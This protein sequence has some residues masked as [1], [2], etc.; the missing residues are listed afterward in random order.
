[1]DEG[2]NSFIQMLAEQEWRHNYPSSPTPRK[3]IRYMTSDNQRPIMTNSESILQFGPN[4]Y[5]KPAT[6]LSILRETILGR[7]IFDDAFMEFSTRWMFKSPEPADFF[8]T[9]E[10][11]AGVDLDWFWRS[12]FYT[13]EHVDISVTGFTR[14]TLDLQDPDKKMEAKEKEKG[15][16]DKKNI[17]AERNRDIPKY[18]NE[19]KGLKDFYDK[20]KEPK[21][22]EGDR[23][24]YKKMLADLKP[25]EKKLLKTN[26]HLT[27]VNF[28]NK[29]GAIMP[30]LVQLHFRNGKKESHKI[31][32][33]IWKKNHE[34]VSKLFVTRYPVERVLID[35][36][37]QTADANQENNVWPPQI[38]EEFF[39]L[40]RKNK[41]FNNDMK[42]A[43]EKKA[44]EEKK[45]V[46]EK[47]KN[48]AAK[49]AEKEKSKSAAK[50]KDKKDGE[51][52]K[53][54]EPFR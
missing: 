21:V 48:E 16:S 24:K 53:K 47:K 5:S 52:N 31:P 45:K 23:E 17:V 10:D 54:A 33:E 14:H 34:A 40:E 4:A 43:R 39:T 19:N 42:R 12:W 15:E 2:L 32:A 18:V 6:G 3:I 11:A 29:G 51:A 13:T 22:S 35:P 38:K 49:K 27:V 46:A 36:T 50:G 30:I 7:E 28:E 8:R 1:M 20:K 41:D 9:M 37:E 26:K 44:A 25:Q